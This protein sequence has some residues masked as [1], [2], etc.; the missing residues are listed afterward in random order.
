MKNAFKNAVHK[1]KADNI[2][3]I[4]LSE[5]LF[6]DMDKVSKSKVIKPS[7][8]NVFRAKLG[9]KKTPTIEK[10]KTNIKQ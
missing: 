3:K 6:V 2:E 8:Q 1:H 7:M 5:V 4:Y 10:R 9:K